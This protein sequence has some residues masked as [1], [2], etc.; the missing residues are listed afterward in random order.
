MKTLFID[1]SGDS[2][3]RNINPKYPV[4]LLC[5]VVVD[6]KYIKV[7]KDEINN[8]K[9]TMFKSGIITKNDVVLHA[10]EIKNNENGFEKIENIKE[11]KEFYQEINK[12]MMKLEYS[13][14]PCAFRKEQLDDYI[15][16]HNIKNPVLYHL[17][18]SILVKQFAKTLKKNGEQ[19]SVIAEA[20]GKKQNNK[21]LKF[22]RT[23]RNNKVEDSKINENIKNFDTA[24]KKDIIQKKGELAG[25]E[26]A[27]LIAV[28]IGRGILN[29]KND[30]I[31]WQKVEKKLEDNQR[32]WIEPKIDK[33]FKK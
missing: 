15:K 31:N 12:L 30:I 9:D 23:I 18:F 32:I 21:L 19:G 13:V 26:I 2:A 27:D 33:L 29:K 22:W 4:F 17:G 16:K 20:R 3:V 25:L 7:L 8:F 5:G 1:E 10:R 28:A 6:D 24:N 14:I 11:R